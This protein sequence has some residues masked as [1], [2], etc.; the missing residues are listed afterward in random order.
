MHALLEGIMEGILCKRAQLSRFTLHLLILSVDVRL[1]YDMTGLL[2]ISW[3][4]VEFPAKATAILRP[5]PHAKVERHKQH[6]HHH[7]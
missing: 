6:P 3:M 4:A 5:E 1:T 7:H 2:N